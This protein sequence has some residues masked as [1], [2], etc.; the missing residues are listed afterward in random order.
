MA[1]AELGKKACVGSWFDALVKVHSLITDK[2]ALSGQN[3][4]L[5]EATKCFFFFFFFG[6]SDAMSSEAMG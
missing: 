6:V 5:R 2:W 3:T 1:L 4:H